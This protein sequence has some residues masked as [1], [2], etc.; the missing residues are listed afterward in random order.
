MKTTVNK[1]LNETYHI[2]V[3]ENGLSVLIWEKPEFAKSFFGLATN[4]GA[5]HLSEEV[6]GVLNNFHSGI[7]HFLEHKMFENEDH[8]DVMN[9]F[10]ALGCSVNAFTS[11]NETLY[12]FTSSNDDLKKP[13]NLL[14]DFVQQFKVSKASVEKEKGIIDSEYKM[15]QQM[16][17]SKLIHSLFEGLFHNYPLNQD[18]SGDSENIM[19]IS[20]QELEL[21]H[22]YNYHPNNMLL[23][24]VSK[25]NPKEILEIIKKNQSQ[26][27]FIKI[28]EIKKVFPVEPLQVKQ[29]YQ[30]IKMNLAQGKIAMGYKFKPDSLVGSGLIKRNLIF[31]MFCDANFT[32]TNNIYQKWLNDKIIN[33]SFMADAEVSERAMFFLLINDDINDNWSKTMDDYLQTVLKKPITDQLLSQLKKRLIGKFIRDFD[34]VEEIAISAMQF[35]W[36]GV[37]LPE[38]LELIESIKVEDFNFIRELD[39]TNKAILKII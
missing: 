7:A 25:L 30:E 19:A 21:A 37:E 31:K 13:L 5:L 8:S 6:D 39:W 3:L 2:E 17:G 15:Y 20:A 23:V 27:E 36:Q 16:P 14:L 12:Y 22:S 10:T 33:D 28:K 34:Q 18:I 35:H 11:Y 29:K 38:V 4:F 32:S 26:K 1:R 9:T 24:A